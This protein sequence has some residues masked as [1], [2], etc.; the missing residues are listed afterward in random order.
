MKLV[1]ILLFSIS[2]YSYA[3]DGCN[4]FVNFSPNDY[5]NRISLFARNRMMIGEYNKF[6]MMTLTKHASHGNDPSFW[7]NQVVEQYNTL[8]LRGSF[9]VK[10]VW[11]T[12]II[13]PFINN[14]QVIGDENRYIVNGFSDPTIMESFQI[15]NSFKREKGKKFVHRLEVGL[16]VKVP[17]GMI[18]KTYEAGVPNLDLQ[19]GTGSFDFLGSLTYITKYKELGFYT[20]LNY[21]LNTFNIDEYKYGNTTNLTF[22]AFYQTKGEK[23]S[24]MPSVGVYV[25]Q[26]S[27]DQNRYSE[28][29]MK[30]L[31]KYADTGGEILFANAGL[32]VFKGDFVL[33]TEFQ[34]VMGSRLKGFTQLKKRYR[35]NVGLAYSF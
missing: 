28:E 20:N 29:N 21:K 31:T 16:G 18:N 27:L 35:I 26:M 10:E 9:Y 2:T 19:P 17:L 12:T 14:H 23:I 25:E 34:K 11:K 5:K 15:Y 22:N 8:E 7:D 24:F 32:K 33:T 4:V 13:V 3:C 1:I 6:G 30:T